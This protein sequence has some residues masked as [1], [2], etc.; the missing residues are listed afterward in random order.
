MINTLRR[1]LYKHKLTSW[2][3]NIRKKYYDWKVVAYPVIKQKRE[4]PKAIF[5]VLTP[6]H[7]NIGDHAITI[8]T[9]KLLNK[10]GIPYIEISDRKLFELNS[11]GF[12]NVF[13]GRTILV[14]GGG[15]LGT[16]WFRIEDVFRN[17][18]KSNK[19]SNIICLP[20]TIYY[21]DSDYGVSE[22][23]N[24]IK[25]YNDH[26][27]LLLYAREKVSYDIMLH[28]YKNVYLVP[29]MVLSLDYS[30]E[31]FERQGCLLCLR[32]DL[33]KTM[34][35]DTL[36]KLKKIVFNIF[37]T[38]AFTD[39]C[40]SYKISAKDRYEEVIKKVNEFK[41][42][43]LVITDRLHGMIFCAITG[44]PCIV[45][46]S[47]SHKVKGCYE[48][49]KNLGYIK[50]A[51]DIDEIL[52]LYDAIPKTELNYDNSNLIKHYEQLQENLVKYCKRK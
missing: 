11:Y 36:E 51:D 13:N 45:L 27:N 48:W 22:F 21:E 44:T 24:S 1:F 15:N 5:Y 3:M 38:Y 33:E 28:A 29:D 14:N 23:E 12:L 18:I 52:K 17:I 19:K 39:M 41:R 16:L 25:I 10:N 2:L 32:S 34:S 7:S 31:K 37:G 35:D 49:I 9:E 20:N 4:N 8:A 42:A 6:E 30:K 50:F 40:T 47:K 26:K 43:E 46:N